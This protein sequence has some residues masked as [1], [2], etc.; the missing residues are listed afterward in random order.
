MKVLYDYQAFEL[1]K[2][3]GISR[4]FYELLRRFGPGGGVAW[5]LPVRYSENEYLALLD[6]Y[7]GQLMKAPDDYHN[8]LDGREFKGKWR[9]YRL[10]NALFPGRD[11]SRYNQRLSVGAL[12][13]GDFKVFH[14]T[15]YDAYFLRH[16]AGK[17]FV[18]TVH[19]LIHEKYPEYFAHSPANRHISRCKGELIRR[20]AKI[21]AISEH[22]KKDLLELYPVDERKIVTICHGAGEAAP[23]APALD[24]L[25][26]RYLLYVGGRAMYKNFTLFIQSVVPLLQREPDLYVVC[27]GE[28]F[29]EPEL[30]LFEALRIREKLIHQPAYESV[31]GRLYR[32][33]VAFVFPSL[34]EGFGLP[35]LEAFSYGCP[36]VLSRSSSL[37]EVGGPAAVYF[38]P[39]APDDILDAVTRVVADNRLREA[40][41]QRGY[42]Q[43]RQFSWNRTAAETLNVYQ[44]LA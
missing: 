9:L 31:I 28:A 43:L 25:P 11:L 42:E 44:S 30:R 20:A 21:I 36:V 4:Y 38:D 29:R 32:H 37:P 5:S 35:V 14:P 19:D 2:F 39:Q 41:I 23:P 18:L 15:Y 10:R 34:Y 1:Q 8:F 12:Q 13:R 26:G 17:P 6:G 24:A 22:T 7:A 33:A 27:T 3:G 40:L 16:L